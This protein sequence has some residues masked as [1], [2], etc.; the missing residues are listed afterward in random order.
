M[1]IRPIN[2]HCLMSPVAATPSRVNMVHKV[3]K[4]HQ[5]YQTD[6]VVQTLAPAIYESNTM[7][8]QSSMMGGNC[9]ACP[10]VVHLADHTCPCTVRLSHPMGR[11][12]HHG[13]SCNR[14]NL[15]TADVIL[16]TI[17]SV[18]FNEHSC[19][20]VTPRCRVTYS[21]TPTPRCKN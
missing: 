3:M 10:T 16:P 6:T 13:T 5:F 8:T 4:S 20:G 19:H 12:S 14:T 7:C 2:S 11:S 21:P 9:V 15:C 17:Y 1:A 18:G